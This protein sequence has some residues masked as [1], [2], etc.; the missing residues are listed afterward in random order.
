MDIVFQITIDDGDTHET[1]NENS[2]HVDGDG[3]VESNER[4]K[5]IAIKVS[6]RFDA[7]EMCA[8]VCRYDDGDCTLYSV[9]L[10]RKEKTSQKSTSAM[11]S[12]VHT[13]KTSITTTIAFR[14]TR[15]DSSPHAE[16]SGVLEYTASLCI[17]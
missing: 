9:F 5:W 1:Q 3:T 2:E 6:G 13:L 17:Q 16:L 14:M 8:C 7:I 11:A 4:S 15:N 10:S 12:H